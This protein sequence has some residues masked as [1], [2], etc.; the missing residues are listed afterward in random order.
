MNWF[1]TKTATFRK[2]NSELNETTGMFDKCVNDTFISVACDVQ[3]LDI[4]V[5]KDENGKLINAQYKIFCDSDN[6]IT[7]HCTVTYNNKSYVIEKI[8]DR[9]DYY[10]VYIREVV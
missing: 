7:S 9:E 8:T 5:D 6:F 1:Y 3:P 10:I 4:T 2:R